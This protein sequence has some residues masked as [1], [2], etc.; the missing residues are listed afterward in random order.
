MFQTCVKNL[1]N[2]HVSLDCAA[3]CE[4]LWKSKQFI[5]LTLFFMQIYANYEKIILIRYQVMNIN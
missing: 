3:I 5:A 1:A 4:A 2:L